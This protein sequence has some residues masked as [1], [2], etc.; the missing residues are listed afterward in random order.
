MKKFFRLSVYHP[1]I[2]VGTVLL[3][4]IFFGLQIPKIQVDPRVEIFLKE[5][6]PAL[7]EFYENKDMFANREA[8]VI[9][10]LG[11]NIYNSQ[12]LAKLGAMSDEISQIPKVAEVGNIFNLS[13]ITGTDNGM[14]IEA[15][16]ADVPQSAAEI[17]TLRH[18]IDSWEFYH[19]FLVTEDASGT[20]LSFTMDVDVDTEDVA[21]IYHAAHDI[22]QKY[23]GPEKIFISGAAVVESLIGEYMLS[24]MKLLIPFVNVVIVIFLFIFFRNIRG[25]LLPL[26]TVGLS[27]GWTIGLMPL[28]G[29]PI[30][31]VTSSMPVILMA[32]GTAYGI[33]VLENVFSDAAAGKT[34]KEGLIGAIERVSLPI[35]MAG[36]TTMAGFLAL[37]SSEVVPIKHFGFLTAFGTLAAL[38][39]SLTFIPAM[40]SILES[41]GREHI[42][43]GHKHDLMGP[44]I[45]VLS[46]MV[47]KG[48]PAIL[49]TSLVI[50]AVSVAATF[51]IKSELNPI[52]NFRKSSPIRSADIILNENFGG[53]SMFNVVLRTDEPDGVKH[54][55]VLHH[56]EALQAK[57]NTVPDVGKTVSLVDFVKRMNQVMHGDDPA[58]YTIPDS[59]QLI[60]QYL[61]LYSFGGGDALDTFVTYE[62]DAT[63][64]MLQIKDLGGELAADVIAM[65]EEYERENLAGTPYTLTATGISR[66]PMEFNRIVIKGQFS[67]LFISLLLVTLIT[68]FIFRSVKLGVFSVMPLLVPILLNFGIMGIF[69]ITLNACTAMIAS[70]AIGV[71]ID[72]SIHFLSRYRH[73]VLEGYSGDDAI[74][75]AI[76][77][78][79]RAILYNALTVTFGML[80]LLPSKFVLI[81]Q[82]GLLNAIVMMSS[83]IASITLLP[84]LLKV[85]KPSLVQA[86]D[87]IPM[88]A[89]LEGEEA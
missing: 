70:I 28:L 74:D 39:I 40:L 57:L 32:L 84:A 48:S 2:A 36:L 47:V 20:M 33:H 37:I 3:I 78:S 21:A 63:Q 73:E 71:G 12:T 41:F 30:T 1:Y 24:D 72:Y 76:N 85:F 5:N 61:L 13:H 52:D 16:A 34:G 80:V 67:S 25:V 26:L 82:M 65:I 87:K 42:P 59:Q 88:D 75:T 66:L 83:S 14:E 23:Q 50:M 60:A 54:P 11:D 89:M 19:G 77:T 58:F 46:R 86:D 45:R 38:I 64:I 17:E 31:N 18:K 4:S 53:T 27:T 43:Q 68:T 51:Q 81:S 22:T 7:L 35:C 56:L 62:Y 29:M 79:G 49:V 44:A 10:I 55:E 6:N 69:G 8:T 15:L 9:G